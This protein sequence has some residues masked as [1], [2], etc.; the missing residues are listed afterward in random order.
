MNKKRILVVGPSETKAR[1]G[2]SAVIREIRESELLQ[3]EFEIDTYASYRDGCLAVRLLYTFWGCLRFML[4]R[5]RY[6]LFHLHTAERGS[7]FRKYFYLRWAKKTGG[8]VIVHIHGAEYLT[9]YDGLGRLGRRVADDFFKRADLVLALSESWQRELE[10]RFGIDTCRT[11]Y[12]GVDTVKFRAAVAEVTACRHSF[13]MLG[14]L[15]SRKGVYDL[16]DAV[17]IACRQDPSLR[18]CIAGDGEVDKVRRVVE[19][20]GLGRHVSVPGWIDEEQKLKYL[21]KAAVIILPSYHEGLPVSVLEGMAA[22][23]AIISTTAGAIPEVV[24]E[25][26]GILVEPGDVEGL[27]AAM[28]RC[29]GDAEMLQRM[30]GNNLQRAEAV[31]GIRRMHEKLREYYWESMRYGGKK[32]VDQCDRT[33]L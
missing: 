11:L 30:S 4:C 3:A 18:V 32:S 10:T 21:K 9:F 7:T 22:G 19:A 33:G 6:D 16:I 31:F 25:E 23:K 13:L 5:Q 29:S 12:N 14:R 28:L 2:M 27:V 15:G 1:G 8:K 24:G 26:N 17:E 20:K